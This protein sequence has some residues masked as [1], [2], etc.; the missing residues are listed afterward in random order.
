MVKD[1]AARLKDRRR[2]CPG[3]GVTAAESRLG[4]PAVLQQLEYGATIGAGGFV[5]F[6]LNEVL[7]REILP[8]LT[9]E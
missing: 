2:L 7:A 5:L 3:I 1:Q 8:Y 6:D 9:G 4:V